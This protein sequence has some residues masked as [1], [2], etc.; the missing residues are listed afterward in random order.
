M[1]YCA[2]RGVPH[3]FFLGGPHLWTEDDR[4]KALAWQ[5]MER[6]SCSSCG[7]RAEEW[8]PD[9]GGDLRAYVAEDRV[10]LGCQTVES[11]TAKKKDAERQRGEKVY[12]RRNV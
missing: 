1:A 6:Q 11:H 9:Q 7:T 3:S 2:P 10:C 4:E 8:D 5:E 12:M